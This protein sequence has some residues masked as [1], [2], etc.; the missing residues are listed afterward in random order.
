MQSAGEFYR[1][2]HEALARVKGREHLDTVNALQW[3]AATFE[4]RKEYGRAEE[5]LRQALDARIRTEGEVSQATF[6]TANDLIGV[7]IEAGKYESA[8]SEVERFWPLMARNVNPDGM[9]WIDTEYGSLLRA[10]SAWRGPSRWP[11]AWPVRRR[12]NSGP[13]MF[14]R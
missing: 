3:Y 10:T 6:W 11:A 14:A 8:W 1:R 12:P 9:Q 13:V 2:L 7:L 5:L 4:L